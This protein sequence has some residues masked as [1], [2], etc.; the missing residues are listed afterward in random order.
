MTNKLE[1]IDK[2][3]LLEW[4]NKKSIHHRENQEK[5][6]INDNY[7]SAS[8]HRTN[9]IAFEDVI[10]EIESGTFDIKD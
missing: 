4:L 10:E 9:A 7:D 6:A 2:A 1:L 5:E 3:K 8:W